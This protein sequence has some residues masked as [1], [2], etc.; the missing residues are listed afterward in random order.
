[1]CLLDVR[2][3]VNLSFWIN[4]RRVV[5]EVTP[6]PKMLNSIAVCIDLSSQILFELVH[7]SADLFFRSLL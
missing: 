4:A 5:F 3:V 2:H 6:T 1:V 7:F